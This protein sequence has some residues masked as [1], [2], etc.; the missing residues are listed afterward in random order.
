MEAGRLGFDTWNDQNPWSLWGQP[1][2]NLESGEVM[3]TEFLLRPLDGTPPGSLLGKAAGAGFLANLEEAIIHAAL[4]APEDGLRFINVSAW[5]L[6]RIYLDS[7]LGGVVIEV[8]EQHRAEPDLPRVLW[9]LRQNGARFALDD[10]ASGWGR[11]AGLVDWH[12]EYVKLDWPLIHGIDRDPTR[13]AVARAVLGI[14]EDLGSTVIAEGI[15]TPDELKWL[16]D[17]GVRLGQ[18]FLL[19]RP[20]PVLEGEIVH[21]SR[22]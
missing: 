7:D 19:G 15:E 5:S 6:P 18:G 14:S 2:A 22:C 20:V 11:L 12:P 1:I 10:V 8:T 21:A 13:Q 3:G 17:H 16:R 4:R 9:R